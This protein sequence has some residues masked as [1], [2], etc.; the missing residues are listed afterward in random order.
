MSPSRPASYRAKGCVKNTLI[1][2]PPLFVK[3]YLI[4]NKW[5]DRKIDIYIRL[6]SE[7]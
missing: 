7:K 6:T 4:I 3:L 2:L 1:I 5:K